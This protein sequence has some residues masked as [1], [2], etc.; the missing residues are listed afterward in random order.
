M[1]VK[2]IRPI[3][4]ELL[5][6]STVGKYRGRSIVVTLVPGDML[7]FQ[8]KG[9]RQYYEVSLHACYRMAQIATWENDYQ[10]KVKT[11]NMKKNAGYKA[12]KPKKSQFVIDRA[13]IKA[14]S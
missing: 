2:L 12:R 7:R 5:A 6:S 9:T 10:D 14:L 13:M 1:A 4:R 8:I 11:Y 3:K